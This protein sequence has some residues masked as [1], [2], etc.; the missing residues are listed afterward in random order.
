MKLPSLCCHTEKKE[1]VTVIVLLKQPCPHDNTQNIS[2][3]V[4]MCD[5]CESKK[6]KTPV[7]YA[8]A[9]EGERAVRFTISNTL[10]VGNTAQAH[11][12]QSVFCAIP[13]VL[14]KLPTS[15]KKRR[16]YL[17]KQRTF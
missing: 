13:F 3:L 10:I 9:R 1:S 4:R 8:R 16:T 5:R 11:L 2:V 12:C 14:E 17:K 15:S 6:H 7:L